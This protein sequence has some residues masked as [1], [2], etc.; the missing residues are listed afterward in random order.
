MPKNFKIVSK[1]FKKLIEPIG[2]WVS[3]SMTWVSCLLLWLKSRS[4]R[5]HLT[6]QIL[7]GTARLLVTRFNPYL[8]SWWN[9]LEGNEDVVSVQ[10][11]ILL[12]YVCCESGELGGRGC[13]GLSCITP[14]VG[15]LCLL[16]K[17]WCVRETSYQPDFM[18]NCPTVSQSFLALSTQWMNSPSREWRSEI[19]PRFIV[20][21]LV[22][23]KRLSRRGGV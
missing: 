14:V 5:E 2:F 18:G 23:I 22:W 20:L 9:L 4:T 17:C 16:L 3:I 8:P 10:D 1:K 7:R 19:S 11:I 21:S 13:S 15:I 6:F 12:F